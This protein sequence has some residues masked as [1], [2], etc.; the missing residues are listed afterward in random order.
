MQE[1]LRAMLAAGAVPSSPLPATS[2]YAD[3]PVAVWFP[4]G[5]DPDDEAAGVPYRL[6]RLCPAPERHALL[7]EH[8]TSGGERR[9]L[10]AAEQLGDPALWWR[11]ADANAVLDP[12]E[13]TTPVGRVLRVTSAADMP[14]GPDAQ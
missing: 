4:P 8:T 14:G 13:L 12:S 11:L 1:Q 6:R 2:R 10:L 9:D 3:T 5:A 7:H